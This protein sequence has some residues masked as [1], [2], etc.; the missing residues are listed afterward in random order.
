[1]AGPS[2][3]STLAYCAA[4][5]LV[6]AGEAGANL[7]RIHPEEL[8]ALSAALHLVADRETG[9]VV[10]GC[11]TVII[12]DDTAKLR[13]MFTVPAFMGRGLGRAVVDH[14]VWYCRSQGAS[15][16]ALDVRVR[17]GMVAVAPDR[18]Y[19][20]RGFVR[21]GAFEVHR[22]H[23]DHADAHL[24]ASAEPGGTFQSARYVLDF[25]ERQVA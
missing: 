16:M 10:S 4:L 13:G 19:R 24:A 15:R 25:L 2:A 6:C 3:R 23:H 1:M 8:V 18:L 21:V 20:S 22:I 12:D 7:F 11:F 14:A 9:A 5:D 17:N